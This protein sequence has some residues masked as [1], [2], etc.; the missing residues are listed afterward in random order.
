MN[1]NEFSLRDSNT[2]SL[3]DKKYQSLI[4]N[5]FTDSQGSTLSKLDNFARFVPRQSLALFLSKHALFEKVLEVHGSIIECGVFMG[6]GLFTWAQ[7]SAIYEPVNHN[8]KI[9]GFDTFDGFPNVESKDLSICEKNNLN[10]KKKGGYRFNASNE[11]VEGVNLYDMNRPVGHIPKVDLIKGDAVVTIPS[12]VQDNPHLVVALLYLDFDL[13]E[14]T[15]VALRNFLPRMPR[16]AI[17]AFD[18]L[19]QAQWPGE[20]LAVLEEIGLTNIAIKRFPITPA[21]SY[22]VLG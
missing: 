13:Y 11:I 9:F 2:Q 18:E 12:F 14:P 21:I 17:L 7:L 3:N 4:G 1:I 19:N 20:T 10:F 5:Y 6:G 15:K 16:G 22:V 8:R